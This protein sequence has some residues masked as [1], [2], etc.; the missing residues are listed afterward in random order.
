MAAAAS[1]VKMM[2]EDEERDDSLHQREAGLISAHQARAVIGERPMRGISAGDA[3][4]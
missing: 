3:R 1:A 4:R 2:P